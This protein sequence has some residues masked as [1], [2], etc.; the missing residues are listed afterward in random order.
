MVKDEIWSIP[1]QRICAFFRR[2]E[3]VCEV[4]SSVFLFHS[5]RITLSELEPNKIGP[6][7]ISRTRIHIEGE[8]ADAKSIYNRFFNQFLSAGG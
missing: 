8:E 1:V 6:W 3:D 4:D 7:E 5:C 2:Q